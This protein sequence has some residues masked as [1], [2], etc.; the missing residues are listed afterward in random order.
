MLYVFLV[1]INLESGEV[2]LMEEMDA[3]PPCLILRDQLNAMTPMHVFASCVRTTWH[4][5]GD[6]A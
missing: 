6:P 2:E 4:P 3:A 1:L 5:D